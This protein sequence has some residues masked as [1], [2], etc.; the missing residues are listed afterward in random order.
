MT[1]RFEQTSFRDF[2]IFIEDWY[3]FSPVDDITLAQISTHCAEYERHLKS[4]GINCVLRAS[5]TNTSRISIDIDFLDEK[6]ATW[7]ILNNP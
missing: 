3:A 4:Q 5:F 7:F 2:Q 1:S 6:S